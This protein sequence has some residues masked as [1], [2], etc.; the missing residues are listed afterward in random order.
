MD[1][2]KDKMPEGWMDWNTLSLNEMVEYLRDKYCIHSSGDAKCIMSLIDYY[3]K[4]KNANKL[5]DDIK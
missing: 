4:Y 2:D 1:K 3:D 5:L